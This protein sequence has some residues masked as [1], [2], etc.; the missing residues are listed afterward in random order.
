MSQERTGHGLQIVLAVIAAVATIAAALIGNWQSI[1]G[2][3]AIAAPLTT[4]T[5]P[6]AEP[7]PNVEATLAPSPATTPGST[8]G[9]DGCQITI[10]NPLTVIR[11]QPD[12][13]AQ[14][15]APVPAGVYPTLEVRNVEFGSQDQRWFRISVTGRSGWI[16]DSS[17]DV[18]SKSAACP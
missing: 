5:E 2:S 16:R 13:F 4:V 17:F 14:E 11:E 6:A 10:A 7:A 18:D 8:G 15:A 1:F 12:V 9:G 3:E